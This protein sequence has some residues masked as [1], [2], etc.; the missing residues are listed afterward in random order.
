MGEFSY[1]SDISPLKGDYFSDVAG[2]T[3]LSSR[4]KSYLTQ[5]YGAAIDASIESQIKSVG[6]MVKFQQDAKQAD[7]EFKRAQLAL[8]ETRRKIQNEMEMEQVLPKIQPILTE[9][10]NNKDIDA[11]TAVAEGEKLRLQFSPYTTKNPALNNVFDNFIK[12][13]NTK[14]ANS[15]IITNAAAKAAEDGDVKAAQDILSSGDANAA[16]T[17]L[18]QSQAEINKQVGGMKQQEEA[19]KTLRAQNK[20]QLATLNS[21]LDTILKMKPESQTMPTEGGG[22]FG[23]TGTANQAPSYTPQ[24]KKTLEIIY[25]R[26]NPSSRNKDFTNISPEELYNDTLQGTYFQIDELTGGTPQSTISKKS[27]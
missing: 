25:K 3:N 12:G 24:Q 11:A 7:L 16:I 1:N 27:E 19:G 20:A 15:A 23:E 26:M 5:K 9:L 4:E 8:D 13:V 2:S 18:A 6:S 17:R 14:N 21:Q 22:K 10:I